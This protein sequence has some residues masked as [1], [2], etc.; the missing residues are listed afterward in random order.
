MNEI[1][2]SVYWLNQNCSNQFNSHVECLQI[3]RV[4]VNAREHEHGKIPTFQYLMKSICDERIWKS[5]KLIF[6]FNFLINFMILI[7]AT[8]KIDQNIKNSWHLSEKLSTNPKKCKKW[9]FSVSSHK[10]VQFSVIFMHH[11]LWMKW[12]RLLSQPT[13]QLKLQNCRHFNIID[14]QS[15]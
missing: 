5:I 12:K 9:A 8:K 4:N 13:I 7:N 14:W 2:A 3:E 11:Q 15:S 1:K 10:L 6:L